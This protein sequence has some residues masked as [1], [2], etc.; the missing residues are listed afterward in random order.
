MEENER[1]SHDTQPLDE[2]SSDPSTCSSASSSTAPPVY[3]KL[4]PL[5]DLIPQIELRKDSFTCGRGGVEPVDYDFAVIRSI[6]PCVYN[7]ISKQHFRLERIR[8]Q[9]ILTDLSF[10]GTYVNQKLVGKF[11]TH[12]LQNGDII[13][14]GRADTLI[15]QY[16]EDS[17]QGYPVELTNKYIMT[18]TALGKGGYGAV[19]LGRLRSNCQHEVAVKILDITQLSR[20]FSRALSRAN[21]VEKEVAIMLQIKHPNCVEFMDWIETQSTAYIVMEL[22]GGGEFFDRIVD[23]KWGGMGFGEELCKFYAWQLLTAVEYLHERG[24]THRDIKPENILC[25]SKDDYT[26]VKLTDFG[27]AKGSDASTMKTFCGTPAYMAPEMIDND[28]TAYNPKVDMWSLGVVLF[29]GISGYPPFSDDYSDMDM[30][31]QIKQ[32]RLLFHSQWK[33]VSLE[34]QFVIKSMLRVD[35]TLRLSATDALKKSWLHNSNAASRAKYHVQKY[36]QNKV[37]V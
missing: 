20:R 14:C 3:A 33:F 28:K 17:R 31:S 35:P 15:F 8:D 23:P 19:M 12:V 13:S 29:V 36:A 16:E 21:D 5:M 10:N 1:E 24:I 27:L 4:K 6:K 9:T 2:H 30:N 11:C 7:V 25:V 22:V 32:G 34:T 37:G 26:V 18:T